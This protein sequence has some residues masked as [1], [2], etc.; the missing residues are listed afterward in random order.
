MSS[1]PPVIR[2]DAPPL[3]TPAKMCYPSVQGDAP[4]AAI[5]F[6]DSDDILDICFDAVFKAVFTK[7]TPESRASLQALLSAFIGRGVA[8]VRVKKN[9][10]AVD[11]VHERQIRFDISCKFDDG[12][13]ADIEMSMNPDDFE[14]VRDE[15]Y[16]SKLFTSQSIRGAD[17]NYG[18][19][20]E[21]YQIS[22]VDKKVFYNDTAVAHHF[23]QYDEKH[24]V[25]LGGKIHIVIVELAKLARFADKALAEMTEEERWAYFFKYGNDKTKRKQINELLK[26]Q[27]AIT[28]AA[29]TLLTISQDENERALLLSQEKYAMDHQSHM[30]QAKRA[31]ISE[32]IWKTAKAAKRKGLSAELIADITDL[33]PD[34]IAHL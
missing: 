30:V 8:N 32:G 25:S 18:D 7:E 26:M 14:P 2:L 21:T 10:P 20:K 24:A 4:M 1:K 23:S 17:H 3:A 16:G 15:Y 22:F 11:D 27:E 6:T 31:G 29:T 19:L 34:E 12:Q 9:E 33:S 5:Q 28:M 13:L